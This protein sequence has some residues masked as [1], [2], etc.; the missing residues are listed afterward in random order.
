MSFSSPDNAGSNGEFLWLSRIEKVHEPRYLLVYAGVR[1]VAFLTGWE[2]QWP[3]T[4]LRS[5][6]AAWWYVVTRPAALASKGLPTHIAEMKLTHL[7]GLSS[8]D[9]FAHRFQSHETLSPD[10]LSMAPFTR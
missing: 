6:D 8:G 4:V 7:P 3:I 5:E 1:C 10:R 2:N 9:Y